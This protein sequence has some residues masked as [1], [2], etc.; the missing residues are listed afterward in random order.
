LEK[1]GAISN[2]RVAI[3]RYKKRNERGEYEMNDAREER[4]GRQN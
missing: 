1:R 3:K 4:H 2:E